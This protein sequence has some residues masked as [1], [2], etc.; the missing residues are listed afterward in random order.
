[1]LNKCLRRLLLSIQLFLTRGFSVADLLYRQTVM[2]NST[3]VEVEIIDVSG[4]SVSSSDD[5][6]STFVSKIKNSI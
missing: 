5:V 3:P 2:I 4:D 6:L 1:M